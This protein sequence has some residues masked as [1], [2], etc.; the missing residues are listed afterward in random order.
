MKILR[1]HE[2]NHLKGGSGVHIRRLQTGMEDLGVQSPLLTMDHSGSGYSWQFDEGAQVTLS[3][4]A[5]VKKALKH[6]LE[7]Q[8]FDLIHIHG[9]VLPQVL[10][11]L[12]TIYDGPIVR[13]MHEPRL[14]C[15]GHGKFWYRQAEPCT[16][17]WGMHCFVHAYTEICAPRHPRKLWRAWTNTTFEVSKAADRYDAIMVASV[18]MRQ[19][20]IEGGLPAQKL[21]KIPPPQVVPDLDEGAEFP[22]NPR[23][24]FVGRIAPTKGIVPMIR[25]LE[26]YFRERPELH[27]DVVGD[28]IGRA[29]LESLIQ[30][31]SLAQQITLHGW[32]SPEEVHRF[33][34]QAQVVVFPSIYPEAFGNVGPEAMLHTRPVVGFDTGGV[35]EWLRDQH[36]GYLVPHGDWRRF[37]AATMRLLDHPDIA[38]KYGRQGRNL[39]IREFSSEKVC[40][41]YIDLYTSLLQQ[42]QPTQ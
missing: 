15:P 22:L 35:G 1:I 5:E 9:V 27:L 33:F 26:P 4:L 18:Y 37:A 39:I 40:Q 42:H 31:S 17:P 10:K 34:Q 25:H 13:Y 24:L 23:L 29:E 20:A 3:S 32:K 6:L 28:G 12:F 16:K 21:I 38:W 41:K 8:S 11:Q 30:S 36:N 2:N 7:H 19:A 14:V